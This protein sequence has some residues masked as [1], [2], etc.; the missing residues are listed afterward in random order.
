MSPKEKDNLKAALKYREKGWSIIPI[1]PREKSPLLLSWAEF[2]ERLPTEEEVVNWFAKWPNANIAIVTGKVSGLIVVDIDSQEGEKYYGNIKTAISSTGKGRHLYFKHPGPEV[3]INRNFPGIDIQGERAYVL[4]P[5]SIHPNGKTYGW[6]NWDLID[7]LPTFY[8]PIDKSAVITENKQKIILTELEDIVTDHRNDTLHELVKEWQWKYK[9]TQ[10]DLYKYAMGANLTIENTEGEHLLKK[11]VKSVT[12]SVY[13]FWEKHKGTK[14]GRIHIMEDFDTI[15]RENVTWL[16]P[17]TLPYGKYSLIIGDPGVGKS[18]FTV[19]LAA[20]VSAGI[21][22]PDNTPVEAGNVLMVFSEDGAG[23]TV[24]PRLE[25][26]GANLKRV[27]NYTIK[28]GVLSLQTDIEELANNIMRT[29]AKLLV[30]D[31]IVTYGGK[32]NAWKD[33]EVR[34]LLEPVI[35]M[36]EKTNCIILGIMHLNKKESVN[37]L[38]KATG[39]GAW[40]AVARS[41]L[42]IG[43][44]PDDRELEKIDRRYILASAKCNLS[45]P[46]P[47]RIFTIVDE[48]GI[49]RMRWA[50]ETTQYGTEDILQSDMGFE[51]GKVEQATMWVKKLLQN[52]PIP[53]N[54]VILQGKRQGFSK[55]TLERVRDHAGVAESRKIGTTW[56]WSPI[57]AQDGD[58]LLTPWGL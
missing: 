35:K 7:E 58:S 1:K 49:G 42:L 47:T 8:F 13:E 3:E 26:A 52:G 39:S 16:W 15:E 48:N 45:S 36:A 17:Q 20:R 12:K 43:V 22:L 25:A 28:N 41:V 11:E 21:P 51:A 38:Q 24:R 30:L 44:H 40:V 6:I 18:M 56:F 27:K 2:Q 53:T 5:P 9:G 50:E 29:N 14:G 31:P 4:A 19:D 46:P 32:I 55:K 23:D 33:D 54:D 57:Q 10:D 34:Q 37:A